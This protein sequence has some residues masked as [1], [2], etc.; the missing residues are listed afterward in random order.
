MHSSGQGV[1]TISV[2]VIIVTTVVVVV[3]IITVFIVGVVVL[4]TAAD[5]AAFA[6]KLNCGIR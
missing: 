6:S 2:T 4:V 1:L 3:L 5:Y